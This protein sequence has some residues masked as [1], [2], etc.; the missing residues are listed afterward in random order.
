MKHFVN[1]WRT[2]EGHEKSPILSGKALFHLIVMFRRFQ[3]LLVVEYVV[4][5]KGDSF[6]PLGSRGVIA[7]II[8]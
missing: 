2:T 4:V 5:L 6:D 1:I 3:R 7:L 8:V